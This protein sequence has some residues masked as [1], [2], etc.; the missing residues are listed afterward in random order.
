[1]GK[2]YISDDDLANISYEDAKNLK[3]QVDGRFERL[4]S[5][6]RALLR[7]NIYHVLCHYKQYFPDD[8]IYLLAGDGKSTTNILDWHNIR[9]I[10]GV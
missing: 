10:K 6:A 3:A 5:E 2:T 1:M 4:E 7:E 8:K 9:K